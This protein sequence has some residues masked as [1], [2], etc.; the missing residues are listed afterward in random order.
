MTHPPMP[1]VYPIVALPFPP[2][3][4]FIG[5]LSNRPCSQEK[6]RRAREKRRQKKLRRKQGR[7]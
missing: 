4:W 1:M 2:N 5:D 6:K 7:H 3:P